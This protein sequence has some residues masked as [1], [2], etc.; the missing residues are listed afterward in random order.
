MSE[1]QIITANHLQNGLNVYYVESADSVTWDQDSAA[2]SQFDKEE[3]E[4][5]L[6]RAAESEK[7]NVVVGIYAIA[8]D[9]DSAREKI[10]A[11]GPSIKYGHEVN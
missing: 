7:N 10:R 5:A 6:H 9:D 3:I 2:A 1:K 8:A 4:E 11:Q